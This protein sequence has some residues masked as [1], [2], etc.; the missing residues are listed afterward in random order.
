[1]MPFAMPL[2]HYGYFIAA[3]LLH[4]SRIRLSLFAAFA[5]A[6]C[7]T[8]RLA[9]RFDFDIFTILICLIDAAI[10]DC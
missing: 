7:I 4:I 10:A 5:I 9:P 3:E 2:R 1:M 6:Y 8:L